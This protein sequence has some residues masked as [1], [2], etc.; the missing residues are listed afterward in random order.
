MP[1]RIELVAAGDEQLL[2]RLLELSAAQ[3]FDPLA[4]YRRD[5]PAT[6]RSWDYEL[7]PGATL[8]LQPAPC[9]GA[10]AAGLVLFASY[11]GKGAYRLRLDPYRKAVVTFG[12]IDASV[13]GTPR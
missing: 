10:K 4:N 5:Y 3:W 7:P 2:A 12:A 13:A 11:K 6:L 1:L 8:H 9:A